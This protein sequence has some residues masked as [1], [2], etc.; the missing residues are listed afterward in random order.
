MK[1]LDVVF[2]EPYERI[3]DLTKGIQFPRWCVGGEMNI[4][5]NLLD[6]WQSSEVRERDALRWEGE[7]GD[8]RTLTYEELHDEVCRCANALRS[9]GLGKGDATCR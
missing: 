4:V 9:L 3:V 7:D 6:K 5:H 1:D 2:Y 8:V